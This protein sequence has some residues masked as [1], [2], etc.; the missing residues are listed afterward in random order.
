M[1]DFPKPQPADPV[2]NP[3]PLENIT[4]VRLNL[5]VTFPNWTG[6]FF[7]QLEEDLTD[8]VCSILK[9]MGL[10][11]SIDRSCPELI[12][13]IIIRVSNPSRGVGGGF[14]V[15]VEAYL[16]EKVKL[17]RLPE[18]DAPVITWSHH[19]SVWWVFR[20]KPLAAIERAIEGEVKRQ[21]DKFAADWA[22]D[23]AMP[24]PP[25]SPQLPPAPGPCV[26]LG[27][28]VATA[29]CNTHQ[30]GGQKGVNLVHLE[31]CANSNNF[32]NRNVG[33]LQPV[34]QELFSRMPEWI[35]L[36]RVCF[37]WERLQP[38]FGEPFADPYLATLKT[39]IGCVEAIGGHVI[40][41]L[42]NSFRY[43]LDKQG[44]RKECFVGE[45][46]IHGSG[47]VPVR[48]AYL[49]E[50]WRGLSIEFKD[51]PTVVAYGIMNQPYQPPLGSRGWDWKAASREIVKVI[52]DN[53]DERLILVD[54]DDGS[55]MA[56]TW[57]RTPPW[58][59]DYENI[60]YQAHLEITDPYQSVGQLLTPFVDWC[61]HHNV[62]GFLGS[63]RI[64]MSHPQCRDMVDS[65]LREI[66]ALG[67]GWC[68]WPTPYDMDLKDKKTPIW[69][70]S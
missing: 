20:A 61:Q 9:R 60:C 7:P 40:L 70:I 28:R 46:D 36:F 48:R 45:P 62:G 2:F 39:I 12:F 49:V 43:W 24:T 21:A 13:E 33:P 64:A 51:N 58:L 34:P 68:Y 59:T 30:L 66:N 16:Q 57:P 55:S 23:N 3:P 31:F 18:C 63:V 47:D 41:D 38:T 19:T 6:A 35:R 32:S 5:G 10:V 25:C 54:T 11:V 37:K 67:L 26:P 4:K 14:S 69:Q 15:R 65:F 1:P 29:G 56:D 27:P 22:R 50:L 8:L 17:P 44:Q 52:R 53:G 42:H